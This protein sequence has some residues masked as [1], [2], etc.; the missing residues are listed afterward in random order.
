MRRVRVWREYSVYKV[1]MQQAHFVYT[2]EERTEAEKDVRLHWK[3]TFY[4]VVVDW[5]YDELSNRRFSPYHDTSDD[6]D[7]ERREKGRG[8][9]Y[10]ST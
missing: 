2:H 3:R 9:K 5:Q 4:V 6:F 7:D 8:W 10:F 1:I